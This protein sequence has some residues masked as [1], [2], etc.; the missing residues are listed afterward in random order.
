MANPYEKYVKQDNPYAQFIE[1]N[2]PA[3]KPLTIGRDAFAGHLKEEMASRPWYER[4]LAGAGTFLDDAALRLKQTT[5]GLT[6]EDVEQAKANRV[7]QSDP[8]GF[9]G[10]VAGSVAALGPLGVTG[11]AGNAAL[12][13][14]VGA[15]GRPLLDGE[16]TLG[17]VAMGAGAGALGGI[18]GKVLTG[19][20]LV[21]PTDATQRLLK[22]GVVPTIGQNA[23]SS[24]SG[25]AQ[26]LGRT[27][28]R[29]ASMP[30]VGD[31]ITGARKRALADFNKA[32]LSKAVP[33]GTK[34]NQIGSEG[35]EQALEATSRAYDDVYQGATAKPT[36]Q[37]YKDIIAA[38]TKPA[39][40]LSGEAEKKYNDLIQR[41]VFDRFAPNMDAGLVKKTIEGDLGKL[42][43]ELKMNPKHS[44]NYNLGVALQ[45]A[46]DAVRDVLNQSVG[47][48]KA[49]KLPGL[50]QTYAAGKT[51]EKASEKAMAQGGVFTPYQLQRAANGGQLGQ[52]ADDAQAVLAS[53]VPNSGTA[54]RTLQAILASGKVPATTTLGYLGGAALTA[55][56]YSRLGSRFL[57]GDL[58]PEQ[59]QALAPYLAQ[60]SRGGLYGQ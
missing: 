51:V 36:T 42:A 1:Q 10:N 24:E 13:A 19:S 25:L 55:P 38:K 47:G 9:G 39:V 17:N 6:P 34:V 8:Y 27:E 58:T 11:V 54:D 45:S 16:S 21:Q 52:L 57:L 60:A 3:P 14:G 31:F 18:A 12:G 53:R 22:Q 35:V 28:E 2:L 43:R 50:N 37:F 59:V 15:M 4:M 49:A 44:D 30:I 26:A 20:P 29:A 48:T 32:A 40:A 41:F 5:A 46:R 56:A 23:A 33:P 7:I